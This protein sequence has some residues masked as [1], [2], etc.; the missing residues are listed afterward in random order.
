MLDVLTD[1]EASKPGVNKSKF[2]E[3][4]HKKRTP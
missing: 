1:G 4:E 3:F 2:P